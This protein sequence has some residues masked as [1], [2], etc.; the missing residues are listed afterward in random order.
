MAGIIDQRIEKTGIS[1]AYPEIVGL[2]IL[3]VQ[4]V[5]MR[6]LKLRKEDDGGTGK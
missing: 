3:G 4:A 6:R 5:S 1:V 2:N